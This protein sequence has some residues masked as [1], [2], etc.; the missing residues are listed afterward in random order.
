MATLDWKHELVEQ[1]D[2]AFNYHF[3]ERMNGLTDE[4]Y[5][6]EPVADV[7]TIHP[8]T[9]GG[10]P[11]IDPQTETDPAPFTTIAWRMHHMTDFFTK[12]WANHFGEPETDELDP[13]VTLSADEAMENLRFA[14]GRW[15]ASLTEMPV[16]RLGQ[17]T[18][19]AEGAFF[20]DYPFA[21]LVL[22]ITRE[23]IHHS[24]ECCLIRDLYRQR[25]SLIGSVASAPRH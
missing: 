5:L 22:H 13:A 20:A 3:V 11:T 9:E 18:G 23:F 16:E 21:A 15:K 4:E 17:P 24:S 6:W 2:F 8:G 14:Y 25:E 19:M 7:W 10:A 1:L 12:R